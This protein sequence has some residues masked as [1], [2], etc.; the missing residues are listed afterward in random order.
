LAQRGSCA[1]AGIFAFGTALAVSSQTRNGTSETSLQR[2]QATLPESLALYSALVWRSAI[3]ILTEFLI[4]H[5]T[6]GD[7][8]VLLERVPQFTSVTLVTFPSQGWQMA[9]KKW[10]LS[11]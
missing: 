11:P 6:C 4:N 1:F 7:Y 3:K 5:N 8:F 2:R 9:Y 10:D